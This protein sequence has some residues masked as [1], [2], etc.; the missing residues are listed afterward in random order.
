MGPLQFRTITIPQLL[1]SVLYPGFGSRRF[2]IFCLPAILLIREHSEP[3][4]LQAKTHHF[5]IQGHSLGRPSFVQKRFRGQKINSKT[6]ACRRGTSAAFERHSRTSASCRSFPITTPGESLL[7]NFNSRNFV[8]Y[9]IHLSPYT[10]TP[11][12]WET[13]G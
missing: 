8:S 13:R 11:F 5:H 4:R 3:F 9:E 6:S 7:A 1:V 2:S 10:V 12:H